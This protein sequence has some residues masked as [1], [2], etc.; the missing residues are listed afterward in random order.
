[1]RIVIAEP[2]HLLFF[3]WH[4][5]CGSADSSCWGVTFS[6]PR[7]R[8]DYTRSALGTPEHWIVGKSWLDVFWSR[9]G[10]W[11]RLFGYGLSVSRWGVSWL[12]RGVDRQLV[13]FR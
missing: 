10:A 4:G 9:H 12:S 8:R 11:F 1:M 6:Y 2:F 5:N 13:R 3:Q 7:L